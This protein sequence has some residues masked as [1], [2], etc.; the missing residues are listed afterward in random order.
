QRERKADLVAVAGALHRIEFVHATA[1]ELHIP[2]AL[3][4]RSRRSAKRLNNDA[5]GQMPQVL[6]NGKVENIFCTATAEKFLLTRSNKKVH[7]CAIFI[8]GDVAR[9]RSIAARRRIET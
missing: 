9:L 4:K 6:R 5:D 7:A 8:A 3:A 2:F 1:F